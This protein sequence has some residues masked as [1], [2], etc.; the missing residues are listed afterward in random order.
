VVIRAGDTMWIP[1]NGEHWHG[2]T[3]EHGTEHCDARGGT[4][5]TREMAGAR[6]RCNIS[7]KP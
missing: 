5:R 6:R 4:R 2:A 7:A 1:S 3:P